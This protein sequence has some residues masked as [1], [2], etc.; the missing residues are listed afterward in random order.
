MAF[1]KKKAVAISI[2]SRVFIALLGGFSLANLV[3]ILLTYF[4]SNN[5]IDA[6]VAGMMVSFIVYAA[7]VMFV[8]STKK[9]RNAG[10]GVFGLCLVT[11]SIITV[12]DM[13][14]PS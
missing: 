8:F 2:F 10:L 1:L 14:Y 9:A 7:V 11:F 5:K 13:V 3:A 4:S 12:L 6:I